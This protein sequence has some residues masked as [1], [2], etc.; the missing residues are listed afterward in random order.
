M[1]HNTD[2][3]RALVGL[4]GNPDA[5]GESF[6]ITS[7]EVLSWN[8]ITAAIAAAAGLEPEIV[9]HPERLHRGGRARVGPGAARRQVALAGLRQL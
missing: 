8:Q 5:A 6:H 7:D 2:F 4:L 3:A 9:P 1:T